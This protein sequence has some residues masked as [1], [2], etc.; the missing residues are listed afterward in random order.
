MQGPR[1][2]RQRRGY[3]IA[4]CLLW[5][6]AVEALPAVHLATHDGHHTHDASGAI[7]PLDDDHAEIPEN[8]FVAID[9]AGRPGPI[10]AFDH[11]EHSAGGL[12]HHAIALQQPAPPLL[13]PL[14]VAPPEVRAAAIAHERVSSSHALRP[15]ARGPPA[16]G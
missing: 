5:L 13:A 14:P 8:D 16:N 4:T 10:T 2:A 15:T 11:L 12:A 6:V 7:I 1:T 9:D 3:A